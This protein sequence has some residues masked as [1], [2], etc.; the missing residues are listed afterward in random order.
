MV[1]ILTLYMCKSLIAE[2]FKIKSRF[3]T[4]EKMKAYTRVSAIL[5][6][7]DIAIIFYL[8]VKYVN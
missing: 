5:I 6:F 2:Q 4:S 3:M 8:I 1:L 7:M